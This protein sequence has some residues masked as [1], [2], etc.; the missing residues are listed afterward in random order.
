MPRG[1]PNQ[2]YLHCKKCEDLEFASI[3]ELRKHQ[4]E[5]H[6]DTFAKTKKAL[7]GGA[8]L[9]KDG[10]WR[11][12]MCN[13]KFDSMSKMQKHRWKA[14]RE[15]LA[16]GRAK[17][18]AVPLAAVPANGDMRVSDLLIE[19]KSQHKFIDDMIA[20]ISGIVARH[21]KEAQ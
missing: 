14:H 15:E 3:S 20:L 4:W 7:T 10:F 12:T 5:T 16:N 1:I 8:R 2:P 13:R 19:L 9:P 17:L 11:C 21:Q 18:P 6:P